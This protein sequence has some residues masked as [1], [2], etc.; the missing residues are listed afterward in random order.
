[1]RLNEQNSAKLLEYVV[2]YANGMQ[3]KVSAS[4]ENDEV[5]VIQINLKNNEIYIGKIVAPEKEE[6]NG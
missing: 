4:G 5:E 6:S 3:S 1:M 2:N